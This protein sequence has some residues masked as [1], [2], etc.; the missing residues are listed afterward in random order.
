MG[1]AWVGVAEDVIAALSGGGA[2]VA[3][4]EIARLV[5]TAVLRL[6]GRNRAAAELAKVAE[7][8]ARSDTDL[9]EAMDQ[10]TATDRTTAAGQLTEALTYDGTDP[11][12]QTA[13]AQL[14]EQ[15]EQVRQL[16][17]NHGL[18]VTGANPGIAV[19]HNTGQIIQ[20]TGPGT[21]HA[22]FHVHGNY[23]AGTQPSAGRPGE[24]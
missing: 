22:P 13:T 15:A 1:G 19:Q 24:R 5:N 3:R 10:L 21:V 2:G 6:S 20:N 8:A 23:T 18:T 17:I 7:A 4:M 12:E 11:A 14:R 16:L 9:A